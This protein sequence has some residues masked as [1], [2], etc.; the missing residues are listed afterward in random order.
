MADFEISQ[1]VPDFVLVITTLLF[2]IRFLQ[3]WY[4]NKQKMCLLLRICNVLS[5]FWIILTFTSGKELFLMSLY[6]HL[7]NGQCLW[8]STH[9]YMYNAN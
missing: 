7:E 9:K 8:Q 6:S 1:N 3:I 5:S 2:F 4:Q